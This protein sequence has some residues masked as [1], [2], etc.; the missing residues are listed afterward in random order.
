[1]AKQLI[2]EIP[3][4]DSD[5]VPLIVCKYRVGIFNPGLIEILQHFAYE[6]GDGEPVSTKDEDEFIVESTGERLTAGLR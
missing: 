6:L 2:A 3:C 5:G 4:L 1:M